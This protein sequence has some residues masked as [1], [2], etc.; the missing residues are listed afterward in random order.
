MRRHKN[1][2]PVTVHRRCSGAYHSGGAW[3]RCANNA[4]PGSKHCAIH[5]D[6]E[7]D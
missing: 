5:Q 1:G 6:E 7:A 3:Y 2:E 4:E